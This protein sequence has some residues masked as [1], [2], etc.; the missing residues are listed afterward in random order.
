MIL[1][2]LWTKYNENYIAGEVF[3]FEPTTY[4]VED[5]LTSIVSHTSTRSV[6][7]TPHTSHL[8]VLLYN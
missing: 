6:E 7:D 5:P 2:T 8:R 3:G 1:I 4:T